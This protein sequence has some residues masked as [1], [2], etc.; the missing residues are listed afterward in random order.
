MKMWSERWWFPLYGLIKS[1]H[2]AEKYYLVR[3]EMQKLHSCRCHLALLFSFLKSWEG[4]P[5]PFGTPAWHSGGSCRG[6]SACW[7]DHSLGTALASKHVF[8]RAIETF[9]TT[10]LQPA[11]FSISVPNTLTLFQ[12]SKQ[13][14][15]KEQ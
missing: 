14:Q 10:Q 2:S 13:C 6:G 1:I 7:A 8:K 4:S 9:L 12:F 5:F 11:A 3:D 15:Q